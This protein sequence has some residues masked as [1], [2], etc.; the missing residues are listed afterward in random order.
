[1]NLWQCSHH[2]CKSTCRGTG[3]AIGLLA[4][5]WFFRPGARVGSLE[6]FC[7]VHR[8]DPEPCHEDGTNLGNPCTMCVADKQA[9][10]IQTV[11]GA[12]YPE[13]RL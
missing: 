13:A 3:G 8:P 1:M 11:I 10:Q 5:G 12:I 2:G 7:P 6:L 9:K 4:I